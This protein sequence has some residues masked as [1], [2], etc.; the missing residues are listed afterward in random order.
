MPGSRLVRWC[1]IFGIAE[2]TARVALSRMVERG[3]LVAD[4]G[5][6]ELAGRVRGRQPAQDWTVTAQSA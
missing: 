6:Y 5:V 2:G 1:G 3:E 4:D